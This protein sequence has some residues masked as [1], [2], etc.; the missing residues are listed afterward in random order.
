[1]HLDRT[2]FAK[3]IVA[4]FLPPVRPSRKAKV[5]IFCDGMPGMPGKKALLELY[6]KKGFWVFA[7]RY[8]G[9]WES[10][11]SF[12]R[13]SPEEDIR[14]VIDA[15]PRGFTELF[16]GKKF[17]VKP[18]AIYLFASSFGGPAG[19]LLSKDPRVT[20]VVAF[21]PVTDQRYFIS[22]GE[23]HDWAKRFTREAFGEAY[24]FRDAD[25]EKQK[26][27]TFYNPMTNLDRVDG[28]K[29]LILQAKDD[30]SVPYPPVKKFSEASGASLWLMAKGGHC[31]SAW[32]TEPR[33]FRRISAFLRSR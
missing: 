11:G 8:R 5:I 10:G 25:W 17:K 32:Y 31:D 14:D 9:T 30:E 21:S 27:G 26:N 18:D 23:T 29:I 3:D 33:F 22:K 16:A 4:E 20:K 15:L 24:R 7:P 28:K 12:L 13:R 2:R 19:I 6:A 1:M